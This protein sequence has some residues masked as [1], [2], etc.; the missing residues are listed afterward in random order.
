MLGVLAM[1][2]IVKGSFTLSLITVHWKANNFPIQLT[3]LHIFITTVYREARNSLMIL[4]V[5][6]IFR[7]IPANSNW[8]KVAM[9]TPRK[10]MKYVQSQP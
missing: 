10:C 2:L 9:K 5:L 4:S 1:D 3:V 7:P 8:L 6:H